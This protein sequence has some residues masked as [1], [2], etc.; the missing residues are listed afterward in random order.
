M[1]EHSGNL[2]G[3]TLM[4]KKVKLSERVKLQVLHSSFKPVP[5]NFQRF[6]TTSIKTKQD[7]VFKFNDL[8]GGGGEYEYMILYL[9]K[10]AI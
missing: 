9:Y 6:Q 2:S 4:A 3:F 10:K 1:I 5:T 8:W 7:I